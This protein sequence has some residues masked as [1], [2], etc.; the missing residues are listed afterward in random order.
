M[1]GVGY[2]NLLSNRW[3]GGDANEIFRQIQ[4]TCLQSYAKL[5]RTNPKMIIIPL[6]I[7][8]RK[9]FYLLFGT[10]NTIQKIITISALY[11]T[12]VVL[13]KLVTL[14]LNFVE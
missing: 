8:P 14:K 2:E 1:G 5:A 13:D 12:Q 7:C 4:L 10:F 9:A 6:K 11:M 3:W